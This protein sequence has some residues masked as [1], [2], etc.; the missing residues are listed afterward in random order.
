MDIAIG[1]DVD[2]PV[3][4]TLERATR[5]SRAGL[6]LACGRRRSSVPTR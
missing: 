6:H 1:L 4:E 3:D 2:G 5:T